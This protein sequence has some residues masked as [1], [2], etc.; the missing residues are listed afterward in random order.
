MLNSWLLIKKV[1]KDKNLNKEL[2]KY[3]VKVMNKA[4]KIS[5]YLLGQAPLKLPKFVAL[6]TSS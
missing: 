2:F 4:G 5:L 6:I 1:G 3:S